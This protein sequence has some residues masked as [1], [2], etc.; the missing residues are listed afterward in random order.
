[1]QKDLN[2]S[3]GDQHGQAVTAL[4][5]MR[6]ESERVPGKNY[7]PFAGQPLYS[8]IL[9]TL[10]SLTAIQQIVVDTDCE[11]LAEEVRARFPSVLTIQRP[12]E[13]CGGHVPMNEV[14]C[15]DVTVC[16]GDFFLQTHCTN[17]L[18]TA[19]TLRRCIREYFDGR[20]RYD[21]LFTVTRVQ[22]RLWDAVARPVNHNP[23][24]L[25]RTQDLPPIFMENSCAYVFSR[26][27]LLAR[28]NRIGLRPRMLEIDWME[29]WD[30]D[31]EDDFVLA[32]R[33]FQERA[34]EM[35]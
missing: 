18:L 34:G 33:F 27:V 21:S 10:T 22:S 24:I 5:P 2:V 20:G 30:I 15:H 23:E 26:D 4:V 17:P 8:R 25:L 35:K 31:D 11:T 1:M 13:L 9:D 19:A 16:E 29:A 14:L 3:F 28:R 32:E 12:A 6:G 7:R